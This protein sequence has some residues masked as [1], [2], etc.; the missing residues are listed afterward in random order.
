MRWKVLV[1]KKKNEVE[2]NLGERP[3]FIAYAPSVGVK[4][5]RIEL[6]RPL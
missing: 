5:C 1:K 6:W 3:A 4:G 2:G